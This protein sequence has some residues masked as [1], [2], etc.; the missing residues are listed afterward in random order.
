MR[1][2]TDFRTA[3]TLASDVARF[4]ELRL[5][6]PARFD[7]TRRTL[8]QVV[9]TLRDQGLSDVEVG[10]VEL[11]LAEALN[12]I[13][14]HAYADRCGNI[15]LRIMQHE[16]GMAFKILDEGKPMPN[17]A[18]PIGMAPAVEV[19]AEDLP[20]GGFGWFLIRELAKDLTYERKD[21]RNELSFRMHVGLPAHS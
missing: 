17:G 10:S 7:T 4:A 6:F 16:C 8:T 2:D 18:A 3:S 9:Q 20:E 12:N 14:E 1:H 5:I 19:P 21:A 15:E 13:V 11:V